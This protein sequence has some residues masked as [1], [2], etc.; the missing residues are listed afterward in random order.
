MKKSLIYLL[1]ACAGIVL[2]SLLSNLTL[3]IKG[4]EWLSYGLNFGLTAPFVLDLSVLELTLGA[5]FRLNVAV[6]ICTGIAL[7]IAYSTVGKR[8]R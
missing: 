1:F 7:L 6:I 3:G 4:L 8:R 5:T 2:G